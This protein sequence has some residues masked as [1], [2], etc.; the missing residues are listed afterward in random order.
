MPLNLERK[1]PCAR[2]HIGTQCVFS[3]RIEET[4]Y[5]AEEKAMSP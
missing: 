2:S 3:R 4:S 1:T 5:V